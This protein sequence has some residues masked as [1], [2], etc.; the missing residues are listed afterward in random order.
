ME[1]ADLSQVSTKGH[2]GSVNVYDAMVSVD[3]EDGPVMIR[4]TRDVCS[5]YDVIKVI[6]A[7]HTVVVSVTLDCRLPTGERV[8]GH[9]ESND[10]KV[11]NL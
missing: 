4:T 1:N 9:V 6:K 10:C 11:R 8:W 2:Q 3:K 5:V 7:D